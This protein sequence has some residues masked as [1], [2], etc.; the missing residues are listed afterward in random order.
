VHANHC[1]DRRRWRC[2]QQWE[3][4]TAKAFYVACLHKQ[5]VVLSWVEAWD[6]HISGVDRVNSIIFLYFYLIVDYWT[7]AIVI[8]LPLDWYLV[9]LSQTCKSYNRCVWHSGSEHFKR[10]RV[11]TWSDYILSPNVEGISLSRLCISRVALSSLYT[12]SKNNRLISAFCDLYSVINYGCAAV[13]GAIF[14]LKRYFL[15]ANIN[16]LKFC[17]SSRNYSCKHINTLWKDAV[18]H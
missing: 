17:R 9:V 11:R 13:V 1:R 10:E 18:A 12:L 16:C 8:G 15:V 4:V 14:P 6:G 7:S 2:N 5:G 3:W